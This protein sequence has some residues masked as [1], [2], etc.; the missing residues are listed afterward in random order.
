MLAR[1]SGASSRHRE[2][3]KRSLEVPC[4]HGI[5]ISRRPAYGLHSQPVHRQGGTNPIDCASRCPPRQLPICPVWPVAVAGGLAFFIM[6]S[7]LFYGH[8]PLRRS[9]VTLYQLLIAAV[10]YLRRY[11]AG[12]RLSAGVSELRQA[13]ERLGPTY[14]KFGQLIASS[15]GLF[16]ERWRSR[17]SAQPRPRAA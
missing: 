16:P 11:L 1:D 13:F 8:P 10:R 3:K 6:L 5:K 12:D 4:V 7:A 15:S 2:L 14:I 9:L 17:V